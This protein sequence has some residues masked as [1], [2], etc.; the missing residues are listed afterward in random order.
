MEIPFNKAFI[1]GRE[2]HYISQAVLNG[3]L[4]GDGP[5]TR[6][7]QEL[8]ES[9]F[10][11]PKV[12]LTCSGTGA[13]EMAANLVELNEGDEVIL[14]SYTFTSTANAFLL[15]GARPIFIDIREDTL[16]IDEKLIPAQVTSRARAICPVHY[17]GVACE[18]DSIMRTAADHNLSVVEDAAHAIMSTYRGR[19]LGSI[20]HLAA[21]SFHETKNFSAGEGGA[22]LINDPRF[23]DRAEI[24]WEKGTNRR[25]FFRGEVDKY[26]WV[27]LGG[28]YLPSEI[29]AAFLLGQ[30]ER[31]DEM[32]AM[33]LGLWSR[34]Y[35][36]LLPLQT[37]GAFRLPIVPDGCEHNAHMFYILLETE[38][39]RAEVVAHLKHLG[40]SAVWHYIPLHSSPFGRTFGY[41]EGQ[42]PVTERISQ[43][44]LRL[45]LYCG[46]A[47]S[48]QDKVISALVKFF[49]GRSITSSKSDRSLGKPL[50]A[51]S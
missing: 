50:R 36:G 35:E 24:I 48:Q 47:E 37:A 16:N 21:F 15:R 17:A 38:E 29:I 49:S 46:L 30:L 41:R 40:I 26:T 1:A 11:I 34:Y 10:G 9:R 6:R 18:M 44:I 2:L 45:P 31:A 23:R 20:G 22:L 13:L 51:V 28:S 33:R 39:V 32:H 4:K 43:T 8:I 7:C 25:K 14:P 5:F 27:D 42:L 19:P 12:L 3:E